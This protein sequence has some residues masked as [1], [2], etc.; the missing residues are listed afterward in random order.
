M[1]SKG[2]F[3]R[4]RYAPDAV[5][6]GGAAAVAIE[7]SPADVRARETEQ[8]MTDDERF[9]LIYSLMVVVFGGERDP[10]VPPE[11]P[12]TAGY[13]FGVPRLG[14][15]PL[16]IT[17]AGLGVTNP[18]AVGPAIPRR[19]CPPACASRRRSTRSWRALRARWWAARHA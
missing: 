16:L 19:R 9:S 6:G 15:P 10:R 1:E 5:S 18:S 4:A 11:V 8:M 3:P 17:D 14:I 2:V 7:E 13:V 12:Q